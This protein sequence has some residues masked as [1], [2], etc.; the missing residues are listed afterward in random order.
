MRNFRSVLAPA[1]FAGLFAWWLLPALGAQ[2]PEI[3]PAP[4]VPNDTASYRRFTLDNGMKVLLLS[5]PTLN[6]SSAALTVGVGS[7]S[8]PE[9]RQGL[10][11]FLEHMLFLGTEK[12]PDV[13]A[14]D[15][16]LKTNGGYNNAATWPDHTTYLLEIPHAAF[17][18]ALDRFSQFFIAPLFDTKFTEREMN[19]VNSEFQRHLENDGRRAYQVDSMIYRPG[20][21]MSHFSIG[22][23]ETL[24]G[25]TREELLDFYHR[26][27]SA[28]VMTLALTGR[29]SLDDLERWAREYFAAVPDRHLEPIRFPADYLPEKAALRVVRV[30]AVKDERQLQVEFPLPSTTQVP[31]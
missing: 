12:Y 14:F 22:N 8:D 27:Y 13:S 28:N 5:D 25:T 11:H 21:P 4:K 20:H 23:R 19:A 24:T 30:E 9:D 7:L 29:A 10:A 18:G 1:V 3:P 2:A 6:K 16:Y 15:A 31:G 26:H 17:A